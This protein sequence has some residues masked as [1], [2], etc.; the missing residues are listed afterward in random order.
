MAEAESTSGKDAVDINT[1]TFVCE[2]CGGLMKFNISKQKFACESCGSEND[3]PVNS[4]KIVEHDF[5]GY[6][7]REKNTVPF[8]GI[9]MVTCQRCGME[10]T[11]D[12][13]QIATTCPMCSSTQI[14]TV[15]QSSGIPPDGVVPFKIDKQDAQQK[16]KEWVKSRWFAPNDFKKKYGEGDLK[17]MYLPFWTYD[18]DVVSRYTGRGGKHRRV[19]GADGR[20]RTVTN[21]T[22][23]NGVVNSSFDDVQVCASNKQD[24]IKGILPFGTI[25]N[26]K[27]F[28]AGYLSGYYAEV[29]KIKAD[30][31]FTEAKKIIENAMRALAVKDIKRRYDA[32]EVHTLN[33]TYSNVTYKHVLLPLWES[34]FGYKGKTYNY[35]VNGETGKVSGKRPYSPVKI[36]LVIIA[37]I[38]A[39]ITALI[40]LSLL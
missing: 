11:F 35:L 9:A 28:S 3:L 38:A 39:I 16:F 34:A 36:A 37:G 12:E 19:R 6:L 20:E 33:S 40:L 32:A 7:E 22:P 26:T 30:T 25:H 14:A 27:T 17:G 1:E 31:A 4:D 10:I 21:W 5:N 23:V 15:K 13:Q 8:A 24:N 29:Y 18:A 2:N